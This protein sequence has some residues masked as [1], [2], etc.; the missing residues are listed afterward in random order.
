ME[1]ETGSVSADNSDTGR[2]LSGPVCFSAQCPADAVCELEA[3]SECDGNRL[4]AAPLEQVDRLRLP[5]ILSD[6]Q[7]PQGGQ[8]ISGASGS[9]MEIPALVSGSAKSPNRL[10]PDPPSRLRSSGGPLQQSAP[11][12]GNRPIVSSFLETI[13]QRQLAVGISGETSQLLAVGWSS[14]TNRAHKSAWKEWDSWCTDQQVDSISCL[15]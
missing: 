8:G 10:P 2:M 9:N 7:M 1:A 4:S 11:T 6:R 12:G 13:R 5:T 15:V 14:G 3:Q